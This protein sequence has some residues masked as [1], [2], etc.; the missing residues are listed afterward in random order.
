MV[1]RRTLY[2]IGYEQRTVAVLVADLR[3]K[4]VTRVIDVRELPLSRRRGF[5]KT[6]LR[7][8]LAHEGI[9]CI[10]LPGAGNA[11]RALR[12]EV[13][14]CLAAYA[15]HL[16]SQPEVLELVL[17]AADRAR[18]ALLCVEHDPR[19]CHRSILIAQLQRAVDLAAVNL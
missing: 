5:S 11:Y 3:A 6:P 7:D 8:A 9:E 14:A 17:A 1:A 10:H 12:H 15:A 18:T 4:R 16:E 2:A 19:S 13:K